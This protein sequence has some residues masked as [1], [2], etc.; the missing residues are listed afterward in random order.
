M[1]EIYQRLAELAGDFSC[2]GAWAFLP[3]CTDMRLF[4][5]DEAQVLSGLRER[6]SDED[7]AAAGVLTRNEGG[8]TTLSASL[9]TDPRL[10]VFLRTGQASPPYDV[11]GACGSLAGE[12][13]PCLTASTD[14]RTARGLENCKKRLF[15]AFEIHD[16]IVLRRLGFPA[17]MANGLERLDGAGLRLLLGEVGRAGARRNRGRG[18]VR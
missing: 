12:S 11:L 13:L 2:P 9:V 10:L 7:L 14:L 5:Q 3:P 6:F 4:P 8:Q 17:T 1:S 15:A 16:V 18:K